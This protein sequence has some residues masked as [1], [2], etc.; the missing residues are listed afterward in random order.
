MRS[1]RDGENAEVFLRTEN[2]RI[3]GLAVIAAEPAELTVVNIFG[4]IDPEDLSR[5]GGQFGIP[6]WK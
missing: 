2:N 3:A 4:P 1:K 6:R 5:L